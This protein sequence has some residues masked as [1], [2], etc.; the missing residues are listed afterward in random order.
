MAS[1]P[2]KGADPRDRYQ[3]VQKIGEGGY[4]SVFKAYDV[5]TSTTVAVKLID[6]EDVGDELDD[7][8]QE[9]AVMSDVNCPQLIKYYA[10]YIIGMNLWI[11]M[12]F[13]EAGSLSDILKESG[14]LD[15]ASIA[16]VMRELL[17]VNVP[18][19]VMW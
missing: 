5:V 8:H 11:I 4:G 1:S 17:M 15:E 18:S 13:L 16:Y 6:L 3:L 10:S 7:V 2:R 12:E 14:P 9:I 19:W